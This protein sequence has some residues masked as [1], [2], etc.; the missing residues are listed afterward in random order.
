MP[1][2]RGGLPRAKSTHEFAD[3][4]DLV[5]ARG[6][7][8]T[9]RTR[10]FTIQTWPLVTRYSTGTIPRFAEYAAEWTR[11]TWCALGTATSSRPTLYGPALITST[12][13]VSAGQRASVVMTRSA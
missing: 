8:Q 10:P 7:A 4:G 6:L 13:T 11:S 5:W 9:D 1:A 3:L 2:S 12:L